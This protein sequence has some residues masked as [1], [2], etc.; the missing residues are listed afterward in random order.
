[1]IIIYLEFLLWLCRLG[2]L[3]CLCED[4]DSIP[5]HTQ[6][7][8]DPVLLQAVAWA[9]SCSS[10]S[11]PSLDLPCAVDAAVIIIII[12]IVIIIIIHVIRNAAFEVL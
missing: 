7:V 3:S 2:I 11:T 10:D 5:G 4:V 6:W 9:C 1:M 8:K 12:V